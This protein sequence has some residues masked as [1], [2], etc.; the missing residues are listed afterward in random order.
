MAHDYRAEMCEDIRN[1]IEW[2]SIKITPSNKDEQYQELYDRLLIE[3]SVTGNASGSYT[4]ST[5]TAEENIAH[6]WGL[7]A[8]ALN[9]FGYGS[10][11]CVLER[12]AEWC[13][14]AI[15]CYLLGEC[16]QDVIDEVAEV[17]EDEEEEE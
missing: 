8:D 15:R 2:N 10:G 7:L 11:T 4:F 13:D 14:V 17:N 16:L 5:W 3:D 1:Y 12:G 6:N 9:E